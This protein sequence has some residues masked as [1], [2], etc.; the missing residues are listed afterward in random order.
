MRSVAAG[1]SHSL[2]LGCDGRVYSWG[3]KEEGQQE[4]QLGHGNGRDSPSPAPVEGPA[5][6]R[7]IAA[8]RHHSFAVTHC[9]DV[10]QWG[11]SFHRGAE[12]SFRPVIVEGFGGVRVR[13]MFAGK[14]TAFATVNN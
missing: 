11:K 10:F 12:D 5:S 3:R 13:C 1:H 4:G 6:V 14:Y 2:A 9:G 8:S 7:Y